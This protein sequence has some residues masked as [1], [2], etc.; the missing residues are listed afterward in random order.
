MID[1]RVHKIWYTWLEFTYKAGKSYKKN[2]RKWIDIAKIR[3]PLFS[4]SAVGGVGESLIYRKR[5]KFNDVK[6][7]KKTVNPDLPGQKIQKGYFKEAIEEWGTAGFSNFDVQAWNLYAKSKKVKASGFNIFTG[8]RI[9]AAIAGKT[10]EKLTDCIISDINGAGCKVDISIVSDKT[11]KLYLGISKKSM[12]KEYSGI[13]NTDHYSFIIDGLSK[14][15]R[16]YF[17]IKNLAVGE[18]AETGIYGFKTGEVILIPID[19]GGEAIDRAGQTTLTNTMIAKTNPANENGTI[20]SIEI[21][22]NSNLT[23]LKIGIFY[24]TNGDVFTTRDHD[25]IGDVEAGSK[26][27]FPVNLNVLAG[28]YIGFYAPSGLIERDSSGGSGYWYKVGDNIPCINAT[29]ILSGNSTYVHSV[30][31]KGQG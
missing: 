28:D 31:G 1:S 22:A 23:G 14:L 3:G 8:L 4:I 9:N 19:I 17:R 21:W 18:A 26:K 11:G 25:T 13:F 2:K 12:L 20:T 6:E 5:K 27:I 24:K 16:Y 10:W 7:Y 29:F 30:Y 15:T